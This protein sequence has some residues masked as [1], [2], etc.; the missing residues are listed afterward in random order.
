ML[1]ARRQTLLTIFT[2]SL[3]MLA[4]APTEADT[5]DHSDT[6]LSFYGCTALYGLVPVPYAEADAIVPDGMTP[7]PFLGTGAQA[8]AQVAILGQQCARVTSNTGIDAADY[9]ELL[10]LVL[11]H[12]DPGLAIPGGIHAV[13]FYF[14]TDTPGI[15]AIYDAW[16]VGSGDA[17]EILFDTT[18]EAIGTPWIGHTTAAAD[19]TTLQ[20]T[21][22]LNGSFGGT[23]F[24][25]YGLDTDG[26]ITNMADYEIFPG[27]NSLGA[28]NVV[29]P[30]D[31]P[32]TPVEHAGIGSAYWWDTDQ[33]TQTMRYTGL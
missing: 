12:P 23:A 31:A 11:V 25:L 17:T 32:V 2:T 3:S 30:I 14:K 8:T 10:Y 24:R 27:R 19:A 22:T 29:F 16:N 5:M 7:A 33:L 13:P 26:A 20:L 6:I 21:T 18:Q 1:L 15:A 9:T 28:A 4:S